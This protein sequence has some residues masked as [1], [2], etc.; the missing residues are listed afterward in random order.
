[1]ARILE[2]AGAGGTGIAGRASTARLFVTSINPVVP[3]GGDLGQAINV[4][5]GF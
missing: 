5:G 3:F 4:P 1:V 2:Y